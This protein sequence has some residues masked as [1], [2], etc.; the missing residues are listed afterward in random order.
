VILDNLKSLIDPPICQTAPAFILVLTQRIFAY[1]DKCFQV[2]DY[3]A[4]L[5][6]EK[7]LRSKGL[8]FFFELFLMCVLYMTKKQLAL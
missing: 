7:N 6:R 3:S 4:N 1:R 5:D 8:R 2:Q